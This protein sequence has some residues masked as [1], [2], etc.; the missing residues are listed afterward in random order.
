MAAKIK[1]LLIIGLISLVPTLL[2]WLVFFLR[3]KVFWSIPLSTDGMA[4]IVANYDGPLYII[5]AKT[6]YNIAQIKSQF[7]FSLPVEYY[8]AHFPLFPAL[9]KLFSFVLGFPY[10]MLSVTV[11][12]SILALYFFNRLAKNYIDDKSALWLTLIFSVFPARWMVVKSVGSPEPLFIAAIIAS[13]Y[14]FNQKKY[15]VAAL[16]GVIAQLT[17]SPGMLLFLAYLCAIFIPP[18]IK[19]VFSP[20]VK[21]FKNIKI[22]EVL[23][24]FL[25]PISLLGVFAIYKFTYNDF[26]AYFHSGDNIHLMF[27]PFQIFNYS[28]PWVGTFWQEEVI[29]VYLFG[30]VGLIRLIKQ[31]KEILAWFTG[32][33]LTS[34][35]FVAHRDIV[36][37][38]LPI[39]PFMLI[40]FSDVLASKEF[41]WVLAILIIPIYLFS[42]AF[43]SQN[44]MPISNWAP[45][46]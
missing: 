18:F 44:V 31:K 25:M 6:F 39:V 35:F 42:I 46:L 14:F 27:P 8:A 33:F 10:A 43:I 23:P 16:W 15:L 1:N 45:F 21:W 4:T 38:S 22:A 11:L 41:R 30:L 19:N 26:F 3:I 24:L 9:I 13:I 7:Q 2:V 36:R 40:A 32:I 29:F 37:Y 5:V 34:I 28:A 17:K 12:S 20:S